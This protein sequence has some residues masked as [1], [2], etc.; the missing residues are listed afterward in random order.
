MGIEL[1]TLQGHQSTVTNVSFSPDGKR[2]AS[3]CEDGMIKLWDAASGTELAT[4]KG[5]QGEVTNVSFSPDGTRLASAAGSASGSGEIKIWDAAIETESTAFIGHLHRITSVSFSPDGTL[6]ASG[7]GDNT[8]KLWNVSTG[9]VQITLMTKS[10]S[11]RGFSENER[12]ELEAAPSSYYTRGVTSVSFSPDGKR[13]AS[14][15]EDGTIKLW[16]TLT[17][18][19]MGTLKG[20][21]DNVKSVIFSPNGTR[22]AS[23]SDERSIKIWDAATGRELT[24]LKGHADS[25]NSVSFR[26]DGTGLASGSLGPIKLWEAAPDSELTTLKG[27]EDVVSRVIFS[28]DRTRLL[29]VGSEGQE[30]IGD[31]KAR[32]PVTGG[33]PSEFI[34]SEDSEE[35]VDR[36]W[37]AVPCGRTVLLV[38]LAYK[39]QPQERTRRERMARPK[40][41]WHAKQMVAAFS[42]GNHFQSVF[43]AASLLK[44]NPSDAWAYDDLQEASRKLPAASGNPSLA[45]PAIASEMLKLPRGTDL[46][47]LNETAATLLNEQICELL[48]RPA[49]EGTSAVSDWHLLR[50]QDVCS[51]FAKGYFFNTLGVLQYRLGRFEDAI[52]SL[53][54]SIELSPAET[55]DPT[56]SPFAIGFQAMSYFRTNDSIKSNE[57]YEAFRST[58]SLAKWNLQPDIQRLIEEVETT[59]QKSTPREV[60]VRI[61]DFNREAT[62]EGLYRHHWQFW[63]DERYVVSFGLASEQAHD[64]QTS[65]QAGS[66]N[67]PVMVHQTVT[68]EANTK[69]RL[70]G[71]IRYELPPAQPAAESTPAASNQ[72]EAVEAPAVTETDS[73]SQPSSTPIPGVSI[74][75]L[76]RPETSEVISVTSDWKQVKLEFITTESET[77]V[78]PGFRLRL[79]G[80]QVS[81]TAWFDDLKLEKVE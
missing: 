43:H 77:T 45:M 36:R 35:S 5:H 27:H 23:G 42:S 56:P 46:P 71:W 33:D 28:A 52:V 44:I 26:P 13:I 29:S 66:Q 81:G 58:A 65:L 79:E 3:G 34:P 30:I 49:V 7:S 8:I 72:A 2:I 16:D 69:Y 50:M 32:T 25:V 18:S 12:S 63:P 61:E 22:L 75:L 51:R 59:L 4:L 41:H 1:T 80:Q 73:P 21:A 38:D 67:G 15:I 54:K 62:F 37:M 11:H 24:T 31:V 39:S 68:V 48:K 53:N 9:T 70:T 6:I 78:S 57:M 14:G 20:H 76:N 40:P 60:A 64:G 19:E 17:G 10:V 47:Q 55:G 74:G